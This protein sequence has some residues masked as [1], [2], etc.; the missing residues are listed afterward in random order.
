VA[1]LPEAAQQPVARALAEQ[2]EVV[3]AVAVG[4]AEWQ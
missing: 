4:P 2:T 1:A 3:A